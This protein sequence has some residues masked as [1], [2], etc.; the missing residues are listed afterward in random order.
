MTY[1]GYDF[2]TGKG[3]LDYVMDRSNELDVDTSDDWTA[4]V[5]TN[6]QAAYIGV[7]EEIVAPWAKKRP[8]GVLITVPE[9][10]TSATL[11]QGSTAGSFASGPS[12]S[13][14]GYKIWSDNDQ[15]CCRIATHVAG[16]T[17]FV[18]DAAYPETGGAAV[19]VHVFQ[20]EY[21]LASDLLA[22][23]SKPFLKDCGGA[24][25]IDLVSENELS[26]WFPFPP[27]Q[28]GTTARVCAFIG[29]QTIQ[30]APWPRLARR[31]EYEYN[32][33]PGVLSFSGDGYYDD[34]VIIQPPED[35]VVVALFAIGNLLLDKEDER[36]G[37]FLQG[38]AQK[39][40]SMGT[41]A[42]KRSKP[43]L[44]VRS[45]YSIAARR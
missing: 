22:P 38:A 21:D 6:I 16:A 23:R 25:D 28:G 34:D 26:S 10:L 8:P 11:T 1:S 13:V 39:L 42:R 24:Y 15:V 4:V 32:Y 29:D 45:Q 7:L 31:Y 44:W 27:Q 37:G 18:L 43:R 12:V 19:S 20:D 14:A 17:A 40:A 9:I 5:Q 3:I 41:L 33:R 36:A 2:S 30:L 35:A